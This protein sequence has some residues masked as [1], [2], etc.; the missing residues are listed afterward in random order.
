MLPKALDITFPQIQI[1]DSQRAISQG[2]FVVGRTGSTVFDE[3]EVKLVSDLK[4]LY[5]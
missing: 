1:V 3:V 5:L 4:N 2:S